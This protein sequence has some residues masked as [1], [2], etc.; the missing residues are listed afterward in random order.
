M[1]VNQD[2]MFADDERELHDIDVRAI[3]LL[4][5]LACR[6]SDGDVEVNNIGFSPVSEDFG[7]LTLTFQ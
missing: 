4:D 7:T 5:D 2:Q 3:E 6:I 1:W